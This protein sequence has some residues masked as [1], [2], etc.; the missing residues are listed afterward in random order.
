MAIID[1]NT[2]NATDHPTAVRLLDIILNDEDISVFLKHFG[3]K[4]IA[5]CGMSRFCKVFIK[6][7]KDTDIEIEYIFDKNPKNFP[8]GEYMGISI[9]GYTEL[10]ET[11]LPD[12]IVVTSNYYYNDIVD[13]L[14]ENNVPL[15]KIL[16]L[17]DVIFGME[18]LER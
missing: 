18:R 7:M 5:V 4:K 11:G 6:L 10:K 15:E 8:D 16:S 9:K 13:E 12:V 1:T 2:R 17:N 14:I 3:W